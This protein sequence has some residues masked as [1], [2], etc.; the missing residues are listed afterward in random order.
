M[1]AFDKH[2][3]LAVLTLL[4]MA[5]FVS[6]GYPPAARWRKPLKLGAIILLFVAVGLALAE[7][8]AWWTASPP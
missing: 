6:A 8:A 7:I 2:Q 3:A 5:L 1:N 4:V